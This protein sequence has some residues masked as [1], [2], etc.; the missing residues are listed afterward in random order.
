MACEG[1]SMK[2]IDRIDVANFILGA[3]AVSIAVAATIHLVVKI[4]QGI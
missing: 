1:N 2:K 4:L 3:C